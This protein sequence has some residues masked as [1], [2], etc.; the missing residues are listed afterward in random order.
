MKKTLLVALGMAGASGAFAQGT[1]NWNDHSAGT[2]EIQ[3]YAPNPANPSVAQTG[4]SAAD[5]P[6]GSVVYGGVPLGGNA[7]DSGP[8]GY[9][10]GNNFSV[11][12]YAAP[13]TVTSFSSLTAVPQYTANFFT[14]AAGTGFFKG[15]T[16]ASDPGI[17]G[18]PVN[19]TATLAL[20]AWYN[21]GGSYTFAMLLN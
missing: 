15:P 9:G 14:V 13:G 19:G 11:Q 2:L 21:G 4:N 10:N 5:T 20:A 7:T 8:T 1:I 6:A 12:L 17:S 18:V 3:I 16:I